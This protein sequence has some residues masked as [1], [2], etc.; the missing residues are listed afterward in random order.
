MK[1]TCLLWVFFFCSLTCFAQLPTVMSTRN[2]QVKF[3]SS[4]PAEDIEA[5]NNEV[6]SKLSTSNGQI[7]FSVLIKG[8]RFRNALMQEHFNENY[9]ESD[10]F[11]KADFK[12][13]IANFNQ[14]DLSKNGT[15]KV[16]VSGTITIHGTTKPLTAE[17]SLEVKEGQIT[18]GSTFDLT[19]KDFNIKGMAIGNQVAKQVKVSLLCRYQ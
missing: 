18:A 8:F 3:F 14:L 11:P 13:T 12:G 5:V 9:L 17:G 16:S 19:L 15:H 2:G 4:T 7:V 6:N 10:K 1:K